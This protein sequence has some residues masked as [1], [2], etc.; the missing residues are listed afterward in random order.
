MNLYTSGETSKQHV[1]LAHAAGTLVTC[2]CH[3]LL[4]YMLLPPPQT[5][6]HL[7]SPQSDAT[8]NVSGGH[9]NPAVTLGTIISGHMHWKRGLAYMAAQFLG[10]IAG[11]QP[12]RSWVLARQ[13]QLG[14]E[15]A[16]PHLAPWLPRVLCTYF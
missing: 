10:G 12:S 9:L 1:Q 11:R 7:P 14:T 2:C 4:T 15:C 5:P 8:A 6:P 16:Q 13:S 3:P